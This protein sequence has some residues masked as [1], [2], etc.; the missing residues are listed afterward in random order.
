[1]SAT[2][3]EMI[4]S[5]EDWERRSRENHRPGEDFILD[6]PVIPESIWGHGDYSA[7]ARGEG[8]AVVGPTGIGKTTLAQRITLARLGIGPAEVLG[9]PV[10]RSERGGL[11]IAADRPRQAARSFRRM[12]Q[13]DDREKLNTRLDVWKGPPPFDMGTRPENFA[14]WVCS[15]ERDFTIIDSL[16][17]M[18]TD[19][20]RDEVGSRINRAFQLITAA[21]VDFVVLHHQRKAQADNPRPKR[22]ADVYGSNWLTAGLGSVIILWGEPGDPI[23]ELSHLKSP[24]E[25]IGPIEVHIDHATGT[26]TRPTSLLDFVRSAGDHGV[27]A[28]DA[29][30][31]LYGAASKAQTQKARRKLDVLMKDGLVTKI[32]GTNTGTTGARREP[33]RYVIPIP[34][35]VMV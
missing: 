17:D 31:H 30:L 9:L 12:V 14:E 25:E 29:A 21:G 18:A 6:S 20:T 24:A 33:D 35:P 10:S 34:I 5:V 15:F 19:L 8:F 27:A 2:F 28:A 7:W 26:L 4:A 3:E 11:Y 23:V 16:K 13:P 22:L 1:M 32:E